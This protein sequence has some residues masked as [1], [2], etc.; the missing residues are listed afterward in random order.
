MRS[1]I[2]S[3][4]LVLTSLLFAQKPLAAFVTD[5]LV[6][7]I[8]ALNYKEILNFATS[9]KQNKMVL[10]QKGINDF[11]PQL[12][13]IDFEKGS[14]T[15]KTLNTNTGF[16]SWY[17]T[18]LNY[19]DSGLYF[20]NKHKL[21]SY[22]NGALRLIDTDRKYTATQRFLVTKNGTY[23]GYVYKHKFRK[24]TMLAVKNNDTKKVLNPPF[25]A[26]GICHTL[27]HTFVDFNGKYCL[28]AECYSY[29]ITVYDS[30]LNTLTTLTKAFE[31][32][33]PDNFIKKMSKYRHPADTFDDARKSMKK[34]CRI[35][36]A[37][38]NTDT[39][40]YV[41]YSKPKTAATANYQNPVQYYLDFWA[42]TP[43]G[44]QCTHDGLIT[45]T[46]NVEGI[47][48]GLVMSGYGST[49]FDI[50]NDKLVVLRIEDKPNK[51]NS[52]Q[53]KLYCYTL[54]L[55]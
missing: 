18:R 1:F 15:P 29:D 19:G 11:R 10:Y 28:F 38:F 47:E 13:E 23:M 40:F 32:K 22:V 51:P 20:T 45:S 39:S 12:V 42:K 25:A 54:N 43:I 30:T 52:K 9:Y 16:N 7:D 49:Y 34:Y 50:I 6:Y 27:P 8:P 2:T 31:T 5:S 41:L 44:W 3:L 55:N 37:E 24:P 48:Y 14:V 36:K 53:T 17:D 46:A 26:I 35:W 4:L 21:Y 33:A